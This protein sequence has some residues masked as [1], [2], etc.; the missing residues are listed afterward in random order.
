M[1]LMYARYF[2]MFLHDIGLIDFDEPFLKL[3]HQG[4]ITSKGAK[5]SKS[6]GNVINPDYFTEHYG[7]DTF[8]MYLMFMGSYSLGGDW[9]DSGINGVSRFLGRIYRI[10]SQYAP[11]IKNRLNVTYSS[12]KINDVNLN[13]RLNNTIK[14]ATEDIDAL[15]FNTAIA[16]C[17]ELVN[18]LFKI[19]DDSKP[20][21]EL[22]YYSLKQL[23]LIIA[24]MAPHLAEE[25]W[26]LV[27]GKESVFAQRWPSYDPAALD[28]AKVTIVVQI[29]GKLRGNFQVAADINEDELFKLI[30]ADE[31]IAKYLDGV[32][33]VKKIFVPGKLLNI[34]VR[35]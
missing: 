30:Q 18:D 23:I 32:Q 25:L 10:I 12:I 8:R 27:G 22:F 11:E 6:K 13:Y 31:K 4:T 17:M 7:S 21:D 24:P 2:C 15:E 26:Q 9:D 33:I 34:V 14:R 29:N 28:L 5:I 35:Q 16:A 19:S 1:H 20:K 3:R